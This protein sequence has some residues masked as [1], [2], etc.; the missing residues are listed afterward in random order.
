MELKIKTNFDFGKL[1][2]KM[3]KIISEYI[4]G[5]AK[6]TEQGTKSNLDNSVK[7]DGKALRS[8]TSEKENRKPL[9]KTGKLYNSI[10]AEKDGLSILEYGYKHHTGKW[11]HLRSETETDNFI[12]TTKS[13][14]E[15]INKKFMNI[16]NKSLKK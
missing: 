7:N 15:V 13:N 12:G 4:T 10:Q 8:F 1:A 14:E 11:G 6:D 2:S 9:I 5:Y 3:P 16:V